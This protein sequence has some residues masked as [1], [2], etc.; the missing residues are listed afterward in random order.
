MW[1]VWARPWKSFC[2]LDPGSHLD[3]I[4]LFIFTFKVFFDVNY[5]KSLY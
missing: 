1:D 2:G 5:F 4:Y 3:V